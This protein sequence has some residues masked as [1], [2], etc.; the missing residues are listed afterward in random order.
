MGTSKL[1]FDEALCEP[2]IVFKEMELQGVQQIKKL[3]PAERI[4]TIYIDAGDWDDLERRVL[5]RAPITEDALALRKQRY[6][7]EVKFKPEADIILSNRDGELE[8]ARE[9]FRK[10]ISELIE[11]IE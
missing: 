10:I 6:Q 5:A 3:Y 9:E 11:S 7:E 8:N 1:E 4:T 2:Q